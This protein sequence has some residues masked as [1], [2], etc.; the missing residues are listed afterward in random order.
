MGKSVHQQQVDAQETCID[1]RSPIRDLLFA[2]LEWEG[3][4]GEEGGGGEVGVRKLESSK[5]GRL[6]MVWG[7]LFSFKLGRIEYLPIKYWK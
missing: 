1:F 5:V 4:G 6:G 7:F 2:G 3:S